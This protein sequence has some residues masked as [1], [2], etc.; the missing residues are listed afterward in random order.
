M[1]V[2]VVEAPVRSP[3]TPRAR[4][5]RPVARAVVLAAIVV[6]AKA[7]HLLLDPLADPA[8]TIARQI[9]LVGLVVLVV[10]W[11]V[12]RGRVGRVMGLRPPGRA[13]RW[14]WTVLPAA[15]VLLG[16]LAVAA[17]RGGATPMPGR[18]VARI[19]ISTGFGE[20]FLFRGAVYGLA[21]R[22]RRVERGLR[23]VAPRRRA[24]RSSPRVARR[25]RGRLR[26]GQ[27]RAD[28]G[29]RSRRLRAA[30]PPL[31]FDVG[32]GALACRV[33]PRRHARPRTPGV[34]PPLG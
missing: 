3:V 29:G 21:A 17:L 26:R 32:A 18:D 12:G 2:A 6:A 22:G 5:M 28:D 4:A 15:G 25:T 20:E 33:E 34:S 1:A 14:A 8:E 27:R 23:V 31:G 19:V 16:W 13:R 30:S 7:V 11:A 10:R 9:I 24:A